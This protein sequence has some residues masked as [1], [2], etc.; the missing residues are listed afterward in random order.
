MSS[1]VSF[2][3]FVKK[4][5]KETTNKLSADFMLQL[6]RM[7]FCDKNGLGNMQCI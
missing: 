7:L 5:Y 4:E 6:E 2:K 1:F 3:L